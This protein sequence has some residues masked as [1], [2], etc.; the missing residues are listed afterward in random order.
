[1]PWEAWPESPLVAPPPW[2][3]VM[4]DLLE[5]SA[6][7][8]SHGEFIIALVETLEPCKDQIMW[9]KHRTFF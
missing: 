8:G 4:L 5:E 1:M 2:A 3:D 7:R 6:E 9:F